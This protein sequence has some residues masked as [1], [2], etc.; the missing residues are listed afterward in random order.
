[1]IDK[2]KVGE[3]K[4]NGDWIDCVTY[5]SL[6]L[7]SDRDYTRTLSDFLAKFEQVQS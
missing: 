7:K 1:M 6:E 2:E 5:R 4:I 3:V